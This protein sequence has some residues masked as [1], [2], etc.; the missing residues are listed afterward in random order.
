MPT[1]ALEI[2]QAINKVLDNYRRINADRYSEPVYYKFDDK[3]V[4]EVVS[5][6]QDIYLELVARNAELE[7]KVKVYEQFVGGQM[8]RTERTKK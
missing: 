4:V 5:S 6:L 2:K 3:Q 1:M 8:N 7:A